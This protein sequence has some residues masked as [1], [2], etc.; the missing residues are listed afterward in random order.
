MRLRQIL[1]N[2]MHKV[3]VFLLI[4]SVIL[5]VASCEK[6]SLPSSLDEAGTRMLAA[7]LDISFTES[8]EDLAELA[9]N[10]DFD[11]SGK[12]TG[13]MTVKETGSDDLVLEIL[14]FE[15]LSDLKAAG[16]YL[17]GRRLSAE[18]ESGINEKGEYLLWF[19]TPKAVA[20][21]LT[22]VQK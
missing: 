7:G 12:L 6:V 18:R 13:Y 11:M 19:G 21:L 1:L 16:D 3:A 2:V 14:R 10:F 9:D 5:L 17:S 4:L 22:E 20:V 15:L 8:S